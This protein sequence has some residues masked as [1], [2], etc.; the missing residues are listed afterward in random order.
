MGLDTE[1]ARGVHLPPMQEGFERV[2]ERKE[3]ES[4]SNGGG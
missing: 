3:G 4:E 2:G 1:N